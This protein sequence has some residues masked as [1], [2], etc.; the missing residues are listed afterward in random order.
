MLLAC[1]TALE[2]AGVLAGVEAAQR[3]AAAIRRSIVS[4]LEEG[5]RTRD[6][7]GSARASEFV[8]AVIRQLEG[9]LLPNS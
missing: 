9:G 3:A 1:A 8:D 6:L 4:T 5:I 2:R 7:G